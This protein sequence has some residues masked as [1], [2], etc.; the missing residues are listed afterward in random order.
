M[1]EGPHAENSLYT[2]THLL[3]LS[4]SSTGSLS[5]D[6]LESR[7]RME[8]MENRTTKQITKSDSSPQKKT[9]RARKTKENETET[10]KL[11]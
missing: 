3:Y 7:Y 1:G 8:K 4:G 9:M 11:A 2:S 5:L 10:E 6:T